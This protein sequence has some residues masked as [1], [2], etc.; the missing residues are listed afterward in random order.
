MTTT[1]VLTLPKWPTRAADSN[2]GTYGRILI[3]A[4]STGMSGAAV[5][6]GSGGA[7]AARAWSEW[8]RRTRLDHS[9][10]LATLV[11]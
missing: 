11:T 4:G 5:L 9:W 8:R 10:R 1:R 6:C 2:K 7:A 3:V